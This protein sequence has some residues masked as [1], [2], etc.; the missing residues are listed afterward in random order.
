[1]QKRENARRINSLDKRKIFP[2][3]SRVRDAPAIPPGQLP[4]AVYRL[5]RVPR[6]LRRENFHDTLA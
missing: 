3:E 5:I 6:V 2:L 1:M 4:E